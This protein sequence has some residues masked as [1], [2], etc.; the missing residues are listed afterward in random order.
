METG[1]D[2]SLPSELRKL[3]REVGVWEAD[4]VPVA[5]GNLERSPPFIISPMEPDHGEQ[6]SFLPLRIDN[7]S[8]SHG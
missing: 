6:K 8:L 5:A 3:A 2:L 7:L 4:L 1:P